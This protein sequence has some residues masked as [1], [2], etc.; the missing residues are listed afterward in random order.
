[1]PR[2]AALLGALGALL[3]ACASSTQ[4][5]SAAIPTAPI[6]LAIKKLDG[7]TL[8][9]GSLRGRVVLLTVM[10]TWADYALLEVPRLKKITTTHSSKDLVVI[11]IALDDK[12]D[13]VRMFA[14]TF[15]IPYY[16]GTVDDRAELTSAAGPFGAI[17]LIPTSF[18]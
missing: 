16:V 12:P 18:L 15:E 7:N 14:R 2:S 11:A 6:S 17:D 3:A 13:M 4:G 1:M 10:T 9:I 5:S 8:T